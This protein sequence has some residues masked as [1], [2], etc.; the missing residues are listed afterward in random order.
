ML[1]H[2]LTGVTVATGDAP[3]CVP[4]LTEGLWQCE[5]WKGL[6]ARVATVSRGGT[7]EDQRG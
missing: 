5:K 7:L 2:T 3:C 4:N 1:A 6:G